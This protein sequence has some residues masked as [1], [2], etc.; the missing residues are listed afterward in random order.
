MNK[1]G[2]SYVFWDWN[3]TLI[4]DLETNFSVINTLLSKRNK[5]TILLSQY[6]QAFTFPIKEFYRR[7]GFPIEG[8]EYQQLVCDYWELYKSNSKGIPLM[9]GALDVLRSLNQKQIRQY[10]LSASDRRMVLDQISAYGIRHFFEDIIAP[11]DGYALGKVELAKQWMSDKN[12]PSSNVIMIGDTLHDYET[13]KAIKV[14]CALVNKG[15]Q[16]LCVSAS[17]SSIMVFDSIDELASTI[18][19]VEQLATL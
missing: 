17:I 5:N 2:Y 10:I 1:K 6:R 18:F 4:D 7:V 16:N 19:S 11:Q 15:H 12:I 14:D 3:G 13:A 9:A 8:E